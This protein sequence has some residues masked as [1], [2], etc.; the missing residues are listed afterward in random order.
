MCVPACMHAFVCAHVTVYAGMPIC[1]HAC[2]VFCVGSSAFVP[3]C[4][5]RARIS[6]YVCVCQCVYVLCV[7][8][9]FIC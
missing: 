8:V 1:L 6:A 5:V 4:C 9:P 3:V 7:F 2:V